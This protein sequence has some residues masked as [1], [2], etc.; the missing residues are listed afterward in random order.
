MCIICNDYCTC[1]KHRSR[2][3]VTMGI[4]MIIDDGVYVCICTVYYNFLK[5]HTQHAFVYASYFST[6]V[7]IA[8]RGTIINNRTYAT[9]CVLE[10]KKWSNK[11]KLM[12]MLTKLFE[13]TW[14]AKYAFKVTS[15][16][17]PYHITDPNLLL[18]CD[19]TH[20]IGKLNME[21]N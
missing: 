18:Y 16:D 20:Q 11:D 13:G 6:K 15:H 2:K 12:N 3:K 10:G 9:I 5:Q 7:N 19:L 14:I 8:C 1:I 17:S 4:L 21:K